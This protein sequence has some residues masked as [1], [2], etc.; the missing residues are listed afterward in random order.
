MH[1]PAIFDRF[2]D[3]LAALVTAQ[4]WGSPAWKKAFDDLNE[5]HGI[6]QHWDR[7]DEITER[8]GVGIPQ[9]CAAWCSRL[10]TSAWHRY[11]SPE[12][13][14]GDPE[15]QDTRTVNGERNLR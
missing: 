7:V 5:R 12:N 10:M 3:E 9:V 4:Q 14:T 13:L 2:Y 15:Q 6:I 1:V 11:P 8:Y